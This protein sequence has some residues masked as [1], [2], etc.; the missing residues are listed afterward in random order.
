MERNRTLAVRWMNE[1]W[2]LR[3][4]AVIDE[5]LA[6]DVLGHMEGGNV[7]SP[8]EF[9]AVRDQLLSAFPDLSI[10]VEETVAE[11]DTVAVRWS[12]TATHS[13]EGLGIAPSNSEAAFRGISWMKFKD[14]KVVESWDS[15]N[16]GALLQS[17]RLA[18]G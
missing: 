13:G 10:S 8:A 16:Q 17:L 12:V 18:G 2:N 1:V 15:W 4:D 14:G 6:E 5:I 9:R 3:S 7:Q 11:R